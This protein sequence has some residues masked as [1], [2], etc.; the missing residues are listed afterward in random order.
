MASAA[1]R[2]LDALSG[3]RFSFYPPIRNI[4]HN[5]WT[6]ERET[7]AEI[8]AR[9]A[10]T[11]QEVWVPRTQLG[12]ISSVDS[13][14]LIV[15]LKRELEYR[16][17]TV[18]PYRSRLVEL[19]GP[20]RPHAPPGAA[21]EPPPPQRGLDADS[22]ATKLILRA[23]LAALLLTL[24]VLFLVFRGPPE[25]LTQLFRPDASTTDQRYL[26]L[27]GDDDYF[28]VLER[29]GN[30][31]SE[32]WLTQEDAPLHFR[33]L[34]YPSRGY[35]VILMGAARTE[36]RYL[37]TLHAD[38]GQPLDAARLSGGGDARSLLRAIPNP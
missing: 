25:G 3:R 11:E 12:E 24:G 4:E 7:W 30:P 1:D 31:D 29:L 38:S 8:L 5:E 18:F 15:G 27:Q 21:P 6:I 14:V 28:V 32:R 2:P 22:A 17:G 16:G 34:D 23:V 10:E 20:P 33:A 35:R 37:G 13:P 19:P 9:N 36:M 26:G